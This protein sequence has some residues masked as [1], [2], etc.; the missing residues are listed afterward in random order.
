MKIL[1]IGARG[2]IG[3]HLKMSMAG[4]GEIVTASLSSFQRGDRKQNFAQL[5]S[6][7]RPDVCINCSGAAHVPSSFKDPL[8]DFE[9]NTA[10]VYEMLAAISQHSPRTRFVH[11]SSAAVYGNPVCLPITESTPLDPVSPYG[12]HKRAAEQFCQEF[13]QIYDVRSVSLR[14]FS[15][16]GPGLRKQLLWDTYC[17]WRDLAEIKLFGTG[18]ETRDFIYIDDVCAAIQTVIKEAEFQGECI[19]VASGVAVSIRE[20]VTMLL[21]ELGGSKRAYFE[22]CKRE[23]DPDAWRA[24]IRT[25]EA[26]GFKN[27]TPI[28]NGI[29]ATAQWLKE[30]G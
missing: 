4:F 12:Y 8:C 9:M 16:Y 1:I 20:I 18:D 22:G 29:K 26:L 24:D 28:I 11:L 19:N 14:I 27:R 7:V 2:F 21:Q 3:T 25:L 5:F 6:S 15:A 17:K 23:G 10:S 13:S 30:Q